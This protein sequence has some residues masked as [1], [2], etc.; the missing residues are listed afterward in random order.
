MK[1]ITIAIILSMFF[2]NIFSQ[3]D[4]AKNDNGIRK[5]AIYLELGGNALYYSVNYDRVFSFSK[6]VHS[7]LRV[8]FF[9]TPEIGS[10]Y[11][12]HVFPLEANLLLGKENNFFELGV[13][14][15]IWVESGG[16]S[17]NIDSYSTFRLGYRH[18]SDKGLMVRTGIVPIIQDDDAMIWVGLGIGYAF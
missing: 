11:N 7:S 1:K 14:Q 8:G 5:N 12:T 17:D 13:G 18:I 3:E 9:T 2:G 4:N 16:Y 6:I 10:G 15:S